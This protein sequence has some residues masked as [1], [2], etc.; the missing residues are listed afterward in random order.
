MSDL[1]SLISFKKPGYYSSENEIHCIF[2]PCL[3]SKIEITIVMLLEYIF[4]NVW[5]AP[6]TC[7]PT[8][9]ALNLLLICSLLKIAKNVLHMY[10]TQGSF[11]SY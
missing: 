8:V 5:I 1:Y 11:T 7:P 9:Y 4:S 6:L 3:S 2:T 10:S